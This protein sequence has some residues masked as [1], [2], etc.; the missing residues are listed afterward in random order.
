MVFL[1]AERPPWSCKYQGKHVERLA[2]QHPKDPS[3]GRAMAP[4]AVVWDRE[5]HQAGWRAGGLAAEISRCVIGS[6]LSLPCLQ[7][8]QDQEALLSQSFPRRHLSPV[9]REPH[10]SKSAHISIQTYFLPFL[11]H[12]SLQ[13]IPATMLRQSFTKLT[14][15]AT[16]TR[17]FSVSARVMAEGDTGAPRSGLGQA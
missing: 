9:T 6:I 1:P 16:S 2:V 14:R 11:P 17:A 7:Q 15:P 5:P 8:H 12:K 3:F 10:Q 13:T 4:V